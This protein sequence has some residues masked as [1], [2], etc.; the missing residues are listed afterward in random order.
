MQHDANQDPT[1]LKDSETKT[2]AENYASC[3]DL[4]RA[5]SGRI[6]SNLRSRNHTR[7][8][9]AP[10]LAEP[11]TFAYF[12]LYTVTVVIGCIACIVLA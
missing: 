10:P 11:H 8:K 4:R 3:P 5:L 6:L 12:Q 2:K 7:H 9:S 1:H